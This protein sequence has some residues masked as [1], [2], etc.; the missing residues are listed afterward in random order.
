MIQCRLRR[1]VLLP[2][3]FAAALAVP[4]F[5]E[6]GRVGDA[7][8][9]RNQVAQNWSLVPGLAGADK[10][11]VK[12][13]MKLDRSGQIIGKPSVMATGGPSPTRQAIT[14]SAY[15]AVLKSAPFKNLP[16]DKYDGWRE[17]I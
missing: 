15:R 3:I 11:H 2:V 12:I 17:V 16:R 7:T 9:I 8:V 10:V 5:A 1:L 14:T 6:D 4:A 13:R